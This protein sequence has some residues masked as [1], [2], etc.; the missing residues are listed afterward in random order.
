MKL[1]KYDH[2]VTYPLIPLSLSVLIPN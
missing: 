2:P 1:Q